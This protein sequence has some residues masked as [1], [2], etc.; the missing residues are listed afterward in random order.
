MIVSRTAIR[1]SYRDK[2]GMRQTRC[3]FQKS[4]DKLLIGKGDGRVPIG[5]ARLNIGDRL[6]R[7]IDLRKCLIPILFQPFLCQRQ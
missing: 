1:L 7:H 6:N 2:R 5:I 4:L 3:R